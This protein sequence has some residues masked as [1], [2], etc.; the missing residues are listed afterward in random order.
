MGVDLFFVLSGFL[1]TSILLESKTAP[2]Y[3]TN[4]YI[5]RVLRIFPIY[6]IALLITLTLFAVFPSMR[7][8][9]PDIYGFQGW[10]WIYLQNWLQ[11]LPPTS[12]REFSFLGHFWSLAIEE[13]FYLLWPFLVW[14]LNKRSLLYLCGSLVVLA[15]ATRVI[16]VTLY[17]SPYAE[18]F[19]YFSTVTRLDTLSLGAIAAILLAGG[20][21]KRQL[22]F[23]SS[24]IGLPSFVV[25][26]LIF[27]T[28]KYWMG[29]GTKA[30]VEYTLVGPV[31]FAV[32]LHGLSGN[33]ILR[34]TWFR[35]LG[36][37]SYGL[38]VI[39]Y[40]VIRL[41]NVFLK[42]IV[43]GVHFDVLF[44]PTVS[45]TSFGLAFMSWHFIEKR[46]LAQKWRFYSVQT[47][48]DG[49]RVAA[50]TLRA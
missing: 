11:S 7:Q 20:Y 28:G 3:F 23:Y 32:L 45:I 36:T 12:G 22:M 49:A 13:Q 38:Y 30:A 40:P 15:L 21:P 44:R 42:R 9:V 48:A 8:A 19:A 24:I 1:I 50:A 10:Y 37:Y 5:R 35:C 29:D 16:A 34:W 17:P 46:I 6:Y 33:R 4:F 31:S 25:F 47:S 18:R 2:H 39:H 27:A 43:S 41:A 26:I 14:S